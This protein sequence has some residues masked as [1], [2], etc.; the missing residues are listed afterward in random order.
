VDLRQTA[1]SRDEDYGSGLTG[2][3][4]TTRRVAYCTQDRT[5]EMM[6]GLPDYWLY[7]FH[8]RSARITESSYLSWT[9]AIKVQSRGCSAHCRDSPDTCTTPKTCSH[10]RS[11]TP[12]PPT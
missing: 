2:R 3:K 1:R 5:I 9:T 4:S 7:D 6:L 12:Q 11:P 8:N 10:T